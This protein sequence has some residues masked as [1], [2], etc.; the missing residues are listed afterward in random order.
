MGDL[1]C[2]ITCRSFRYFRPFVYNPGY[3]AIHS[4]GGI[5]ILLDSPAETNFA[6]SLHQSSSNTRDTLYQVPACFF[7]LWSKGYAAGARA[8]KRTQTNL[9]PSGLKGK[10]CW[11]TMQ[12]MLNLITQA[13]AV[14]RPAAGVPRLVSVCSWAVV[15]DRTNVSLASSGRTKRE[16]KSEPDEL[17]SGFL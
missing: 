16:W 13:H 10:H 17:I 14:R 3:L 5:S 2:G 7:F 11:Q 12:G 9:T 6:A 4:P 8:R 1:V 15:V